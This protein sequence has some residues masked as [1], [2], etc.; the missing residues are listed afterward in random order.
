[1]P[2]SGGV[3]EGSGFC[4]PASFRVSSAFSCA[5]AILAGPSAS[6][7]RP[8]CHSAPFLLTLRVP[9]HRA[10][11]LHG[12]IPIFVHGAVYSSWPLLPSPHPAVWHSLLLFVCPSCSLCIYLLLLSHF[13]GSSLG[14]SFLY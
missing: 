9:S 10:S 13:C 6:G 1:M 11:R 7:V 2:R 14:M 5:S 12:F 4:V 8:L 3:R